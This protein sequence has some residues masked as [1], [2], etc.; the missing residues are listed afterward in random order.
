MNQTMTLA[1]SLEAE[2]ARCLD[3]LADYDAIPTGAFAAGMIR[4]EL[5]R[6]T[7]A[8]LSG[9]VVKMI[10]ARENLKGFE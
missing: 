10:R 8:A 9:D 7:H 1:D 5:K 6:A 2:I 3:L 4:A